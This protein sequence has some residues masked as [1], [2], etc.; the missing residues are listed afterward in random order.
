MIYRPEVDGLRAVA[1]LPVIFFH[2]GFSGF[3]GGYVGV[4][5]FLVISGYLITSIILSERDAGQFSLTGFYERRARRILPAL[6]VVVL[7]CIPFAW[8]WMLPHE[9]ANFSRSVASIAV[10]LSNF[11][12]HS[13]GSYFGP[14]IESMPLLHA[15]SLAIEEQFY[16]LFPLFL[17]VVWR[18]IPRAL[19]GLL[20]FGACLSLLFAQVGGNLNM[21]PPYIEPEFRWFAQP[22]WGT[23]YMTVGRAWELLLGAVVAVRLFGRQRQPAS[24]HP[25]AAFVGLIMIGYAV[26]TFDAITPFPSV[27]ALLPT[28]GTALVIGY[29]RAD[30]WV[31][32][33]L[34]WQPLVA[35]GLISYSAYLWHLPLLVFAR[36]RALGDLSL[37]TT[38]ALIAVTFVLAYFT[39]RWVEQPCRD[40]QRVARRSVVIGGIAGS[41]L[42][43]GL[44][45]VG[46][47]AD[48][49]PGR[50]SAEAL[51]TVSYRTITDLSHDVCW[52]SIGHTD[53]AAPRCV[54]GA[55]VPP[56]LALIG[57]SH[58]NVLATQLVAMVEE[59]GQSVS[60]LTRDGCAPAL[61][62][63]VPSVPDKTWCHDY[64]ETVLAHLEA[65][66]SIHT[67]IL[68]GRWPGYIE[69]ERFDNG[70]GQQE[71]GRP[72]FVAPDDEPSWRHDDALRQTLVSA[73]FTAA[74]ERLVA[75]GKQIVLVYPV[76]EVGYHVPEH[77]ARRQLLGR[78]SDQSASTSVVRFR[79]RSRSAY[80][81][82]D[83]AGEHDNLLRVYPADLFCDTDVPGRC[84]VE[85]D[86]VPLYFD[87]DHLTPEAAASVL[88]QIRLAA[89][90]DA[91]R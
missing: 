88:A 59:Q 6:F 22:E 58:A 56:T 45:I 85:K 80:Q 61:G 79:E 78:T 20:V 2:A 52:P 13:L 7:A 4:D 73:R 43:L 19:L 55:G 53:P 3:D 10:F 12:F 86:G 67:I 21:R 9:L 30:D 49:F 15:W 75:T 29:A 60:V 63:I 18:W 42:L 41:V 90:I 81:A 5:V 25:F 14:A 77:L 83:A 34:S 74:I 23:F 39:W 47:K 44:G 91:Q 16:L 54:R 62:L 48:G 8:L 87:A 57:D 66:T 38:W 35:I 11:Y 65:S 64:Y 31:G 26:V 17:L 51:D 89:I 70:E 76:P 68:H 72:M 27:Y 1:V 46:L 69:P 82:L 24:W 40:R 71:P 28:I 33:G 84:V 32:R 36:L 50:L 37:V